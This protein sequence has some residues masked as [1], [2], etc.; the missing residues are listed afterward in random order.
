M[1]QDTLRFNITLGKSYT[2]AEIMEVVRKCCLEEYV[3]SLPKGLDTVI[4]ENGKNLPG[5]QRQRIALAR[6]LI[7]KVEYIILDEGTS[8]L[9]EVNAV[10]IENE[11]LTIEGLG[12]ILI[13]HNLRSCIK[14]K[15]TAVYSLR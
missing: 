3:Q 9:D 7:R 12:V 10:E 4:M 14:E 15:L 11:L 8:A 1:F 5:G 13:S 6:A 2:D